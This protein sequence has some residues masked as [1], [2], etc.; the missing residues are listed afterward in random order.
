[1]VDGTVHGEVAPGF[2]GVRAAVA[3]VLRAQGAGGVAVAAIVDGVTVCDVWGGTVGE[4]SLVHTWS[5]IKP[6]TAASLLMTATRAGMALSTPVREV[7]PELGA[8]SRGELTLAGLLA[9][10]A[11]VV[12][13]PG[14][15]VAGLIDHAT[16][17]ARLE[18]A[19]EDWPAGRAAGEHALTYGHLVDGVLRRLDGRSVGRFLAAE[20]AEPH[21][22]D[23]AIGLSAGE[24]AR[25]ADLVG[26]D[27]AWWRGLGDDRPP[28]LRAAL[29]EGVTGELVNGPA[30]RSAEIAAV[31]GHATAR[32]MA[33][34]WWWVLDGGLG[35]D[36]LRADG[37]PEPDV[38]L[39]RPVA[40]T[41]G[42]A[43]LDPGEVGMGGIGGSY[44]GVRPDDR[45]AW[46]FLTTV[47][48][49]HD[50]AGIVEQALVHAIR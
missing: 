9:H 24:Q 33:R 29:G 7:W 47:M 16:T 5:V 20:I 19:P 36:A 45:L 40:W 13:V 2:D 37:P 3:R 14:G 15:D 43:Q 32:G 10:R 6:V 30:W 49:T 22:C 48:G 34:F 31:N 28:L 42:G 44:A 38:V 26:V 27:A 18:S 11:G 1:M 21:G 25:V 46:C 23:I 35:P 8:G 50:R 12:T 17:M 41:L 4:H 39:G